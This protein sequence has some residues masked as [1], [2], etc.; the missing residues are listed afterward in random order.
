MNTLYYGDNLEVLRKYIRDET[1]DLCYIDPPFN[2]KRNYNQIYNNIGGEDRA[3]AQAFTDTW[4]WDE[5]ADAGFQEILGNDMGRFAP[6]TVD[7]LKGLLPVLKK[8]SLLAYLVSM[9]LRVTEIHRVLKPTASFYLHCDHTAS[10][11]LKL[12]LDT[13]FVANGG[14]FKNEIIW[15]RK[16]GRGET[17]HKSSRFGATTDVVLFYSKGKISTFNSQFNHEAEGYGAYVESNFSYT[18]ENGRKY[19]IDNLASPNPR[20]NLMYEY[21]GYPY[22]KFGWAVSRE[23]MEE[24]DAEGRLHFPDNPNGRI[25]RKRYADELKGRPVQ[26]LWDDINMISSQAAERLGYPTQKPE[27][28]LERIIAA[29]SNEG[30]TVLDAYC[31]CGTTVAVAERLKRKWIGIDITYQSIALIS[32]RLEAQ[33]GKGVLDTFLLNGVPKDMQSARALALKKDDR[34]RKEF[35]KW[36]VLT[37]SN[38]RAIIKE[39]KGGD[40]GIDG[41]AYFHTGPDTNAKIVFQVK[42]GNVGRGDISKMNND[43]QR[44]NAELAVFLTLEPAT[45]GMRD[46]AAAAGFFDYPYMNR[47]IPRVAIVTIAEMLEQNV[48]MDMP[49]TQ[50]VLKSARA[51]TERVAHPE[52]F[53]EDAE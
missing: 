11:Y 20:A 18:D 37:Y 8:G 50:E 2:S 52:L 16:T 31:G 24:M 47:K 48:H 4:V 38:N 34:V 3:Q 23:R 35:E 33:Y 14:D 26:N 51:V 1:V 43:R 25:R 21:K 27:A 12:V 5:Q 7:L 40:G 30:D 15:K 53:S 22:P 6:E 10:H 41:T 28:L 49:L 45:K 13:I 9:A 32:R 29:S 36:A 42:S 44:E 39:K 46:E 17:N 19:M